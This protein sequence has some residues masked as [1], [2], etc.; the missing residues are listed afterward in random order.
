VVF[1][2]N[3][4]SGTLANWTATTGSPLTIDTANAH[5]PGG[6]FSARATSPGNRMHHNLIADNGGFE[7]SSASWFTA[8]IYDAGWSS[9]RWHVQALGYSGTGWPNG[10]SRPDGPRN[11][12]VAIGKYDAVTLPGEVW[13]GTKHQGRV[14]YGSSAGYSNLDAPGAPSRWPDWHEFTIERLPDETT[15]NFYVDDILSRTIAGATAQSWD[16][17][18]MGYGA[19]SFVS[20]ACYDGIRVTIPEPSSPG[21]RVDFDSL[22]DADEGARV[23]PR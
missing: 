2:N 10:G 11:Q 3:F 9:S 7:V 20:D 16:T 22:I 13:D 19:G 23:I 14:P 5:P 6:M 21:W 4:E 1:Y 15:V 12:L 17:I 18:T 8:C